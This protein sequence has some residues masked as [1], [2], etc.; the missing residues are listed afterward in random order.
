M[1]CVNSN[2]FDLSLGAFETI[3][4]FEDGLVPSMF[5]VLHTGHSLTVFTSYLV[6]RLI[7]SEADEEILS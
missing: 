3:S 7:S 5:F 2:S 4:T 1:T 6:L